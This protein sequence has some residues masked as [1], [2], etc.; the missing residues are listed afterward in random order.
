MKFNEFREKQGYTVDSFAALTDT[1]AQKVFTD[2]LEL[3]Q[4]RITD[5]KADGATKVELTAI[6]DSL[7]TVK[8]SLAKLPTADKLTALQSKLDKQQE[9]IDTIREAGGAA[10]KGKNEFTIAKGIEANKEQLKNVATK[11]IDSTAFKPFGFEVKATHNPTDIA[12]RDELGLYLPGTGKAP[13]RKYTVA[14]L[15]S[16]QPVNK[17]FIKYMEQASVTRDGKVVIA[18]AAST[19]NTKLTWDLKSEQIAKVRD[20]TN[21]CTDMM[22]DY[23]FVE[24]EIKE[25]VTQG[26]DG[27]EDSEILNGSGAVNSID[28]IASEFDAAN[29]LAVYTGAF[30]SPTIAELTAAMKA[31]IFTFGA[32]NAWDSNVILMNHNDMVK[33]MHAKDKNDNYLLPNFVMGN[34]GILNGMQI[35]TSPLVAA[36]TLFVMDSKQ[37]KIYD[38]MSTKVDMFFEN[39]TNAEQDL[40]TVKATKRMQFIV[41]NLQ[42]NAFMKCTDIA[43]A[44]TAITKP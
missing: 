1:Q 12:D 9:D 26:V 34:G 22:D 27:K 32:E 43:A 25:L 31:Q 29:V 13:L 19:H 42:K 33:F 10:G 23:S 11:E 5:M 6:S 8:E 3:A 20:F 39:G 40:V 35:V 18:C 21:I 14:G 7:T 16:R 17:E 36:N 24:G 38:R 2:Y 37:G 44:L 15:F 41:R 4:K 30:Q 28:S